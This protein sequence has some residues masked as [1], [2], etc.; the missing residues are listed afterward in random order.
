MSEGSE[1]TPETLDISLGDCEVVD[2]VEIT[3]PEVVAKIR[4]LK[5]Q[6]LEGWRVTITISKK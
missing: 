6:G 1:N 5:D 4:E 2:R 3:K